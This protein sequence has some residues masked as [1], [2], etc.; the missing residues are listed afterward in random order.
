MQH[1][2]EGEGGKTSEL[3]HRRNGISPHNRIARNG[4]SA[5]TFKC[6]FGQVPQTILT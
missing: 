5:H 6:Y 2:E 4:I 3:Y 1:S